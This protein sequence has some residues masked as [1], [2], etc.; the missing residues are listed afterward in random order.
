MSAVTQSVAAMT[1]GAGSSRHG[2]INCRE[3]QSSAFQKDKET[4]RGSS[5]DADASVA[6]NVSDKP[7]MQ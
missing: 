7:F 4:W 3:Q 6:L 1:I 5:Y 2:L